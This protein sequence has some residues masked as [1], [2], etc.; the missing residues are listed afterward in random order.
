MVTSI[1]LITHNRYAYTHNQPFILIIQ[2]ICNSPIIATHW[3]F[4]IKHNCNHKLEFLLLKQWENILSNSI[5][6]VCVLEKGQMLIHSLHNCIYI[7]Y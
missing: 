4:T 3:E 1:L 5:I 6:I 7:I 2:I